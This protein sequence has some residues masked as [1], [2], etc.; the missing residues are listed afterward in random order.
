MK[1]EVGDVINTLNRRL[2]VLGVTD[3]SVSV[4]NVEYK[5]AVKETYRLSAVLDLCYNKVWRL[6][7]AT[8]QLDMSGLDE[9]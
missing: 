1:I 7:K 2:E 4:R 5:G 3:G 8:K 9:L 6:E